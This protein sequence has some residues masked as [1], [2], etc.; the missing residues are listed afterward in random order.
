MSGSYPPAIN[1][2]SIIIQSSFQTPHMLDNRARS[3]MDCEFPTFQLR[4]KPVFP[5][6]IT[7]NPPL[8]D[9]AFVRNISWTEHGD[10]FTAHKAA[11]MAQIR[12]KEKMVHEVTGR[13]WGEIMKRRYD[14]K[15]TPRLYH[16]QSPWLD[17]SVLAARAQETRD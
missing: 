9:A 8:D 6:P 1:G 4:S 7:P 2:I 12:E 17:V 13:L 14:C 3:F 5:P 11:L 10:K 15:S 16:S